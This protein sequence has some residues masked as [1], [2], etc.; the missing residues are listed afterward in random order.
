M[1]T[2]EAA[3][4]AQL[5]HRFLKEECDEGSFIQRVKELIQ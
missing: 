4:K 2:D 1:N 5:L 3:N